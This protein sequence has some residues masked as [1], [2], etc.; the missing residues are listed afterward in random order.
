[1]TAIKPSLQSEHVIP[2]LAEYF[3]DTIEHLTEITSGEVSQTFSFS[4]N[5]KRY[6]VR[7]H[8]TQ[9][10]TSFEKDGY[11]ATHFSSASVPIPPLLHMDRYREYYFAIFP[12]IPGTPPNTLSSDEQQRLLPAV[13]TT[14]QAIHHIDVSDT[15]YYGLFTATGEGQYASW[16]AFLQGV[17]EEEKE[18]D[19]YGRWHGLFEN[20]FLERDL[21]ERVYD[22]M[23]HLLEWCPT[24]RFLVHWRYGYHSVLI[25][26]GRVTGVLN[27][28]DAA[29]GD[30]V[31]DIAWLGY[32]VPE[33]QIPT[34]VQ[35]RYLA[36]KGKIPHY[37]ERLRCY[38][39]HISLDALRFFAKANN[40]SA[41]AWVRERVIGLLNMT[42]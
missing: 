26:H 39:C 29:Y 36:Q 20:T 34:R 21:F 9:R 16:A 23:V 38:E 41:Y 6:I 33:Q 11:A 13:L 2:L 19:F 8:R 3:H 31:Y 24:E 4:S 14:L 17:R 37:T 42:S 30:F 22:H 12:H 35:Q 27:W 1:M 40:P 10:M 7:F 28:V 18:W 15:R 32:Y 25:D 5:Q